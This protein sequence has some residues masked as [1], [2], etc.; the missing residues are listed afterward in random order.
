[1]KFTSGGIDGVYGKAV[2]VML[3]SCVKLGGTLLEQ[4]TP[5]GDE[6]DDR[7]SDRDFKNDVEDFF[8]TA[9]CTK[10][11][12]DIQDYFENGDKKKK[13][14]RFRVEDR[15]ISDSGSGTISFQN[16]ALRNKVAK[17]ASRPNQSSNDGSLKD[18]LGFASDVVNLSK[19]NS[20]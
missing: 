6:R 11:D 8:E 12:D 20:G 18:I 15:T 17:V 2:K 4:W 16:T 3:E 13:R 10:F 14:N 1:M 19:N 9:K 7:K 5:E